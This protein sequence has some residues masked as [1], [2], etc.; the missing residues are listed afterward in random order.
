M[1]LFVRRNSPT[2]NLASILQV[3]MTQC[4]GTGGRGGRTRSYCWSHPPS[5]SIC[6]IELRDRLR[7]VWM[8]YELENVKAGALRIYMIC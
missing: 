7:I 5:L 2:S 4:Q 6:R 1:L 3:D 8:D